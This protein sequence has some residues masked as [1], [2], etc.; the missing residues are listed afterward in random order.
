MFFYEAMKL[1]VIHDLMW[2]TQSEFSDP[3]GKRGFGTSFD[4]SSWYKML[5]YDSKW[6]EKAFL[7]PFHIGMW[8]PQ[9]HFL[10]WLVNT[11]GEWFHI[12]GLVLLYS[13]P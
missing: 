1:K 12:S 4:I 8:D 5:N 10:F 9:A 13:L 2:G 3:H 11:L 6:P 7:P